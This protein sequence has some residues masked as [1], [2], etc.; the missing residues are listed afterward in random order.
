MKKRYIMPAAEVMQA[1]ATAMLCASGLSNLLDTETTISD[2]S[3]MLSP[4]LSDV[5]SL[6]DEA[7]LLQ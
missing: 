1:D 2:D 4:V 6:L 7:I 3:E 5:E